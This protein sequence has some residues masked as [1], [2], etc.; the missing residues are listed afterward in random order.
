MAYG[1][2]NVNALEQHPSPV[3]DIHLKIFKYANEIYA[4]VLRFD[5]RHH[6]LHPERCVSSLDAN[7]QP[8]VELTI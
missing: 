1:C 7:E 2:F 4:F 3:E 6:L 5:S 8:F